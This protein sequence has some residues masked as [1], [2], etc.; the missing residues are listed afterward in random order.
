MKENDIMEILRKKNN[1]K[2]IL[3]EELKKSNKL[4]KILSTTLK[5][6]DFI[7]Q[8]NASIDN[9]EAMIAYIQKANIDK[10][11]KLVSKVNNTRN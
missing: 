4:F 1:P 6:D 10:L 9:V 2:S 3:I 7:E 8:A 5:D 11:E